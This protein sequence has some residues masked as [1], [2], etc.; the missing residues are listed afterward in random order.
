MDEWEGGREGVHQG[1]SERTGFSNASTHFGF[2]LLGLVCLR[3]VHFA[4]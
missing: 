2:C 1:G 3:K 4:F